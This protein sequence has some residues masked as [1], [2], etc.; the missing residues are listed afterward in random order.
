MS[1]TQPGFPTLPPSASLEERIRETERERRGQGCREEETPGKTHCFV[2]LPPPPPPFFLMSGCQAATM[3]SWPFFESIGNSVGLP[4]AVAGEGKRG[5]VW[6]G[7][8]VLEVEESDG[9][10]EGSRDERI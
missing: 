1:S 9:R 10:A 2:S 8:L 5:A 6:G 4:H 3:L 7:A